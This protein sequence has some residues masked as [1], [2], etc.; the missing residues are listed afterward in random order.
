MRIQRQVQTTGHSSTP[1]PAACISLGIALLAM[2][3]VTPGLSA[4][5]FTPLV[6]F[7]GANGSTPNGSLV[8]DAAGNLYGT[9]FYGGTGNC[10]FGCGTVFKLSRHGSGWILAILYDF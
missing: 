4:Q 9:T 3:I 1:K 2:I 10:S 7:N 6:S 5:Q 8:L